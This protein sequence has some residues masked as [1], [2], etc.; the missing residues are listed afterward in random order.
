M[1]QYSLPP[2]VRNESV[3]NMFD[4][5]T[6]NIDSIK[7]YK[8]FF[9]FLY[10]HKPPLNNLLACSNLYASTSLKTYWFQVEIRIRID[11]GNKFR[12]GVFVSDEEFFSRSFSLDNLLSRNFQDALSGAE[13]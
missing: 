3:F 2:S 12:L 10:V 4:K 9:I 7:A 11:I 6:D 5:F 13:E 8:S 1:K